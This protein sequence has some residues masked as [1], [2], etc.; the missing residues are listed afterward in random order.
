VTKTFVLFAVGSAIV[1]EFVESCKR[2]GYA[3][4]AGIVN[5]QT[6]KFLPDKIPSVEVS[7]LDPK[8]TKFPCLCPLF[9]PHNR[10][11]ATVEAEM[12]GFH[13]PEPLIDKTAIISSD[14]TFGG[15]SYVNA[16]V[17]VGAASVISRH[18]LI[19]RATSIG[20]HARIDE[21]VS[22]GPGVCVAGQ[23]T[24]GKGAMIGCGATIGPTVDVGE[25]SIVGS[26]A[27]VLANVPPNRKVYGVPA[28][29][30]GEVL[31]GFDAGAT[32][33]MA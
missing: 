32:R 20:H 13:F 27:V 16:G 15:G 24:V 2:A 17:V 11:A 31:T 28:K 26:G 18:A 12:L 14:A 22:I 23:V 3:V 30:V 10:F 5:L 7:N 8:L 25:N 4:E 33:A 1:V 19:N 29:V 21:F 6:P 9:R